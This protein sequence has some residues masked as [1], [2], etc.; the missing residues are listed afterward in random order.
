MPRSE[1][2]PVPPRRAEPRHYNG[3]PNRAKERLDYMELMIRVL[4]KD[5]H[6]KSGLREK[7][8]GPQGLMNLVLQ[9]RSECYLLE[10]RIS[11]LEERIKKAEKKQQKVVKGA[12]KLKKQTK[13]KAVKG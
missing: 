2:R 10:A 6:D 1:E 13:A 7:I 12:G 8:H 9:Y 5:I 4:W 3:N 11:D